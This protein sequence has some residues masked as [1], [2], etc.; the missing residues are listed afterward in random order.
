MSNRNPAFGRAAIT[1]LLASGALLLPSA[2]H[3]Q[4]QAPANNAAANEVALGEIIVTA[5]KRSESVQRVPVSIVALQPEALTDAGIN[6][7]TQLQQLVPSLSFSPSGEAKINRFYIRGVGTYALSSALESSVGVAID[8]VPLARV[9][10]SITDLVDIE[11]VEVLKGPQG[12]LYGKNATA[13]LVGVVTRK[14]RIGEDQ[15]DFNV[16]YGSYNELNIDGAVN[17]SLGDKAAFRLAAWRYGHEGYVND[18]DGDQK[19]NDKN[20]YGLRASVAVEPTDSL[21]ITL[22][23]Q[24]DGK[25][26]DATAFTYRSTDVA[27]GGPT[28]ITAGAAIAK[29]IVPGPENRTADP[30]NRPFSRG[31]NYYLT[32]LADLDLGGGY[33]LSS[34]TSYRDVM[35]STQMDPF[36]SNSP[37]LFLQRLLDDESFSQFTQ[38]LRVSSPSEN[39]LSFVAGLFY[40]DFKIEDIQTQNFFGLPTPGVSA[41]IRLMTTRNSLQNYAAFGELTFKVTPQFRIIAGV[42]Q[43]HDKVTGSFKRERIGTDVLPVPPTLPI[44][45]FKPDDIDYDATSYRFGAQFDIARDVMIYATAARGYK[46]PGYNLT[47]SLTPATIVN[48][49]RVGAEIAKSYEIGIKSQFF[50]RKLTVNITAFDSK[51]SNFQT[52]VRIPDISPPVFAIQNAGALK[53][54]GVEFEISARPAPGLTMGVVG[55]YIDAR[56]TDFPNA[57]CYPGQPTAATPAPGFCVGGVQDL[58]GW[59]LEQSPKWSFNASVG[60]EA[61]VGSEYM[62]FTNANYSYRSSVVYEANRDPRE[63]QDAYGF[64]NVSLGFGKADESWKLS[65]YARNLFNEYFVARVRRNFNNFY[66]AT[67]Y[68]AL[69]RFGVQLSARF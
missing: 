18:I 38:E 35:N 46:A 15:A 60:Y 33:T 23:G 6:N 19:Y 68:E 27:S 34:V 62:V 17:V 59:P 65:V 64:A 13:G 7:T 26:E 29:G 42:R 28:A 63:V 16:S 48:G 40:Y 39:R 44:M 31:E 50:D 8:G 53:S 3:A 54:T 61:P 67:S 30:G 57:P 9:G 22:I 66:Q 25:D 10:G 2:V 36:L 45:D 52:T 43:S 24:Y 49:A 51:F 12:M 11:R 58:N 56:Y 5:N 21:S 20:S 1:G 55:A 32:A 41:A 14:P 4:S 47:Q 37:L 69:R